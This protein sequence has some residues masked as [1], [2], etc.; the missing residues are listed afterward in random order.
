MMYACM[1]ESIVD[2]YVVVVFGGK[3][4]VFFVFRGNHSRKQHNTGIKTESSNTIVRL[5]LAELQ[6]RPFHS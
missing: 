2:T 6:P 3:N 5:D 4:D 1:A